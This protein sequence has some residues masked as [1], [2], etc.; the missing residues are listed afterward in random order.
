MRA[1][2]AEAE[3]FLEHVRLADERIVVRNKII[4]REAAGRLARRRVAHVSAAAIHIN[5]KDAGDKGFC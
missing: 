2:Q 1:A 3:K 5:A 4:R